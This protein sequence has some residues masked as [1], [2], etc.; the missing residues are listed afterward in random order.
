V[1]TIKSPI[2]MGLKWEPKIKNLSSGPK[3]NEGLPF[4][5]IPARNTAAGAWKLRCTAK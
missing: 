5:E 2:L 4:K 3:R 1:V